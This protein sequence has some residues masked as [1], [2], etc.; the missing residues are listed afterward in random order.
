MDILSAAASEL[1]TLIET[2]RT[3][4]GF[5][6]QETVPVS[7]SG[8]MSSDEGFPESLRHRTARRTRPVRPADVRGSIQQWA[9]RC[10]PPS[11]ADI[12]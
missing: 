6:D 9:P 4:T 1:V 12:R 3:L 5:T 10:T 11:T 8:G 2:T 7:Y